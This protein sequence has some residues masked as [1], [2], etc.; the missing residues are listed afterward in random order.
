MLLVRIPC[1]PQKMLRYANW[2]KQPDFQSGHR[3]MCAGSSPVRS[4]N[5]RRRHKGS[6][7]PFSVIKIVT[8]LEFRGSIPSAPTKNLTNVWI[9]KKYPYI[10]KTMVR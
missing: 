3:K 9:V 1:N 5:G 6:V 7:K 8:G 2:I 4:T 10:C